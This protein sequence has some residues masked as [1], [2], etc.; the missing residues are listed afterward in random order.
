MLNDVARETGADEQGAVEDEGPVVRA[1]ESLLDVYARLG[2]TLEQGSVA[3]ALEELGSRDSGDLDDFGYDANFDHALR[4]LLRFLYRSW[5]RVETAG[6]E[7]VPTNGPVILVANYSGTLFAY[8]GAMLRFAVA[9]DHGARRS[10]RPLL[11]QGVYDL[12]VLGDVM[13]RCGGV[14][15]SDENGE[16]LLARDA[17]VAYFPE[18]GGGLGRPFRRRYE[19]DSF[20]DGGFVRAALRSG[21]PVVPVAIVGA[22]E[23]HPV[24]G[25]LDWVARK[26]GMPVVPVTPTFP[27]LGLGGLLPLPSRWRIEFGTPMADFAELGP[28]AAGDGVQVTRLTERTR[29]RVASLVQGAVDRR[30]RAFF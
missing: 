18:G 9:E 4:P 17:V 27:W 7:N 22:E 2:R 12:P 1:A 28:Q 20:G 5:W 21:A 10:V 16:S 26:I 15:A 19:L 25:R 11:D 3:S 14:R 13:A 29:S 6:L 23:T 8:D 24:L 30:G